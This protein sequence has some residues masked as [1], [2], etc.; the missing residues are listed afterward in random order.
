MVFTYGMH[1]KTRLQGGFGGFDTQFDATFPIVSGTANYES[2]FVF[3]Y[4]AHHELS[5]LSLIGK[6]LTKNVF[7]MGDS[8]LYSHYQRDGAITGAPA[9]RFVH[10]QTQHLYSNVV[11]KTLDYYP[12]PCELE[13]IMNLTIAARDTMDGK[14]DG[15]VA[16]TDLWKLNFGLNS[17]IGRPYFCATV[18]A[19]S[20]PFRSSP[21]TPAQNG[22]VT[23]Q[24]TAV[25][26]TIIGDLHD[27]KG[28]RAYLS[29]QPAATFDD[30]ATA[31]NNENDGWELSISG[32]RSEFPVRMIELLN[33]V[34]F[35]TGT[36]P[37]LTSFTKPAAKS[38]TSTVN[39]RKVSL[40]PH[41][42][43]PSCI[44]ARLSM[45]VLMPSATGPVFIS[46]Q[47]QPTANLMLTTN[48]MGPSLKPTS[49][50]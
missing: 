14:T 38:F 26:A 11:E 25:A 3:G 36:W 24:G 48:Q 50:S 49:L 16:R 17:T 39:K 7:G 47:E 34:T 37:D 6:Q 8:K 43:V 1:I 20:N 2:L 32:L 27:S 40:P 12:S 10:Q 9:I 15:V 13:K 18:A 35:D 22:T 33:G 45:R 28:R 21:A 46:F 41:L 30:A 42:S 5:N 29:Y 23:A 4:Q 44:P 19:S 31:Y